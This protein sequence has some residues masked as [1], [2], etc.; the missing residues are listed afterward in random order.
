MWQE[1]FKI[2]IPVVL[3]FALLFFLHRRETRLDSDIMHNILRAD[4][5][6][7]SIVRLFKSKEKRREKYEKFSIKYLGKLRNTL[8]EMFIVAS[9]TT[10]K[11]HDKEMQKIK[12]IKDLIE[13]EE[14]A[15]MVLNLRIEKE[16]SI[17][18]DLKTRHKYL[19]G[20][21]DNR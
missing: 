19:E 17:F 4:K 2:I 11:A 14:N 21:V 6:G 13:E 9:S 16:R 8:A 1:I 12:A 5:P 7:L 18:K 3:I 15:I 10:Q 20:M